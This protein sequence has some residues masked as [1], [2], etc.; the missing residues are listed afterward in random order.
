MRWHRAVEPARWIMNHGPM[1]SERLNG[2]MLALSAVLG[3]WVAS[4]PLAAETVR[5][6]LPVRCEI[7]RTCFVQHHVDVDPTS[8][9]RDFACGR[10]S[11]DGHEG[12]DFRLLSAASARSGVDVVAAADGRVLRA[13][14]QMPDAFARETGRSAVSDRECGNGLVVAHPGGLETQYCHLL[15]GSI[16]VTAGQTVKQG[17]VLG[18]VGYS[19]LA[20][21]AHLHF[22]VRRDGRVLDPFTG[23]PGGRNAE[24]GRT[25]RAFDAAHLPPGSL[26]QPTA[27]RLLVYRPA[28]IIQTG[29]AAAIPNWAVL[30][31]DHARVAAVTANSN[32][33]V[34]YARV[35]NLAAG[36]RVKIAVGG[37]G[38]FRVDH[39]TP[40]L[41]NAK[42][43]YVAGAGKR[44][45]ATRW[46]AGQYH[47]T[48]E[49]RREGRTVASAKAEFQLP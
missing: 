18:K 45:T 4:T 1:M 36:D 31:H 19:G 11:Y 38:G 8:E 49:I 33:L 34:L 13:R 17:A 32:G 10:A 37:P 42:A 5:F 15:R 35:I 41:E 46:P 2:S 28:E 20:D 27:A 21:F 30:E 6:S 12:V 29:F 24:A 14:D 9:V 44:L 22:T 23:L 25:C 26:W 48:V 40:P 39:L 16:A 47:G 3:A 43:I 7:G